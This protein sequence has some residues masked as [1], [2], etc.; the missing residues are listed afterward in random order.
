M[1]DGAELE[2]FPNGIL[3]GDVN[4]MGG[5]EETGR[6]DHENDEEVE[7]SN[8]AM[9]D[10]SFSFNT[11]NEG[12]AR[13]IYH[14]IRQNWE[15]GRENDVSTPATAISQRREAHASL[16]AVGVCV[17]AACASAQSEALELKEAGLSF[18]SD[19]TDSVV[20]ALSHWT[21][22]FERCLEHFLFILK[23]GGCLVF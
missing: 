18:S 16:Q 7:D 11:T 4:L 23:V 3:C 8:Q 19:R 5:C 17:Q 1:V 15:E 6:R 21:S 2:E 14:G 13:G 12:D 20:G 9:I 10:S 22:L